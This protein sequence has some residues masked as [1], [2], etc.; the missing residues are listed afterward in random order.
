[1]AVREFEGSMELHAQ[2]KPKGLM[3]S[4]LTDRHRKIRLEESN[5]R[6]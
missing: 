4:E 5:R 6:C 1:M 3:S 2:L